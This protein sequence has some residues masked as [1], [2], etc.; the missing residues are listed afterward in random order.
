MKEK[1][2]HICKQFKPD[3]SK[4]FYIDASTGNTKN[5]CKKC[6]LKQQKETYI[7]REQKP[8]EIIV[9][10]HTDKTCKDCGK[11]YPSTNEHFRISK[12]CKDKLETVCKYCRNEKSKQNYRNKNK[13]KIEVNT[14]KVEKETSEKD[15]KDELAF[16]RILADKEIVGIQKSDMEL[17]LRLGNTYKVS[18]IG[19]LRIKDGSNFT[20][21]M[22]QETKNLIVLKNQKGYIETFLKKDLIIGEYEI[23]PLN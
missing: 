22:I 6:I 18:Q 16:Q 20:G 19:D 8:I 23:L 21:T 15:L 10:N 17:G 13:R 5:N 14:I 12:T 1:Y 4:Y 11:T 9:N 7:P 2:C 3:T